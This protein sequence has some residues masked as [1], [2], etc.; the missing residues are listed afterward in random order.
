MI[1][2]VKDLYSHCLIYLHLNFPLKYKA[3]IL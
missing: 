1:Q 3:F 2:I